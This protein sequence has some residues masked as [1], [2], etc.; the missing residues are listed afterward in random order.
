MR[1]YAPGRKHAFQLLMSEASLQNLR[2][3]EQF[4]SILKGKSQRSAPQVKKEDEFQNSLYDLFHIAHFDAL[5]II[6]ILED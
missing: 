2:K 3:V 5:E 4:R 6:K 1:H